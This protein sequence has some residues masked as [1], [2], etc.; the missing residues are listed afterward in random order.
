[1]EYD[2]SILNNIRSIPVLSEEEIKELI[3]KAQNGDLIARDKI[4]YHNLRLVI[5][6]GRR[7]LGKFS[8]NMDDI[9]NTGSIGLL[10][11][12]YYFKVESGIKF[13]SY[14]GQAIVR[15][16][17]NELKARKNPEDI[18]SLSDPIRSDLDGAKTREDIIPIDSEPIDSYV[19]RLEL[20]EK[21]REVIK[22]LPEREREIIIYR[23][24]FEDGEMKS[25]ADVG[26]KFGMSRERARQIE[27][28]ILKKL[29]INK[30]LS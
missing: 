29:G 5:Y 27:P 15:E 18:V 28:K 1:M 4:V 19:S 14:A 23:F 12:I 3:I 20:Y 21:V 26:R 8:D 13:S 17:T 22:Q 11:S 16:Y 9:I 2:M 10:N 30:A 7:F 6:I 25:L 24:G